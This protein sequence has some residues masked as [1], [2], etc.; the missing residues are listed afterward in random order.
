MWEEISQMHAKSTKSQWS[1]D[2]Q[3]LSNL[4]RLV[5]NVSADFMYGPDI[6]LNVFTYKTRFVRQIVEVVCFRHT[7][8]RLDRSS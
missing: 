7:A 5:K 8:R 3:N 1:T 6:F 4:A 2:L